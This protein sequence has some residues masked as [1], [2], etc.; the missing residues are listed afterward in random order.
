ML[1][2]FAALLA[3]LAAA[4][5]LEIEPVESRP[6]RRGRQ[7]LS[8]DHSHC[9]SEAGLGASDVLKRAFAWPVVDPKHDE[10]E[11]GPQLGGLLDMPGT[12][13]G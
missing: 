7:G 12:S 1:D 9:L 5:A 8:R 4:Q 6:R 11:K 2:A 10:Q 13:G 3:A